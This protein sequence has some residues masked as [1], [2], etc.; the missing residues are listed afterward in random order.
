[1]TYWIA[2]LND[3]VEI[4]EKDR[5]WFDIKDQVKGLGFVLDNGT[6]LKLPDN[7]EKYDQAKTASANI[8]GSNLQIESRYLSFKLGNK[9]VKVRVN[10]N[11]NNIS[12]EVE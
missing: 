2:T 12:I 9:T 4:T 11:S 7:M 10:E 3:G 8:D 5:G 6:T 1:M